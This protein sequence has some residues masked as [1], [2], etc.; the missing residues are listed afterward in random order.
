[1]NNHL[2]E[3]YHLDADLREARAEISRHHEL[4]KQMKAGIDLLYDNW[5]NLSVSSLDYGPKQDIDE[6]EG[7]MSWY[8]RNVG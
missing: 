3:A 6:I 8:H 7:F 2:H 4:I 5:F 1:M